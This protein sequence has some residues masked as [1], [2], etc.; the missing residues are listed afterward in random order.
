MKRTNYIFAVIFIMAALVFAPQAVPA[1]EDTS[2]KVDTGGAYTIFG[3]PFT[4]NGFITQEF[5][6]GVDP[7]FS[8][9]NVTDYFSMQIEWQYKLT[10][11]ISL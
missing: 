1:Q 7:Y 2:G 8:G 11:W 6:M 9:K 3:K 10:D 4:L 5:A